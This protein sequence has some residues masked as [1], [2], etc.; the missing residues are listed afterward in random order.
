MSLDEKVAKTLAVLGVTDAEGV[1][2]LFA[3][4]L[5][6]MENER[7]GLISRGASSEAERDKLC[8]ALRDRWLARK[9]GRLSLIDDNWLKLRRKN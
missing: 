5:A 4:V 3:E 9:N 6:A 2:A 1:D 7:Q 8:K